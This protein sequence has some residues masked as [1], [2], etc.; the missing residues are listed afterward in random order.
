[1]RSRWAWPSVDRNYGTWSDGARTPVPQ[2][3]GQGSTAQRQTR[4]SGSGRPRPGRPSD[5]PTIQPVPQPNRPSRPGKPVN[6]PRP[7][8]NR[9]GYR[10][11]ARPPV[12]PRPPYN[13]RPEITTACGVITAGIRVVI[14][15]A[16]GRQ[17]DAQKKDEVG[18]SLRRF[19]KQGRASRFL[20]AKNQLG[21]Q[22]TNQQKENI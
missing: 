9:P 10:P 22:E 20:P 5:R 8:P 19:D 6:R 14:A 15:G 21:T 2:N 3:A 4:P 1:M 12:R 18:P 7:Q 11:P 13:W 17:R 16:E